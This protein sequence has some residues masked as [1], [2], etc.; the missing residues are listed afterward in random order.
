MFEIIADNYL[1]SREH[2][3]PIGIKGENHARVLVF[4]CLKELRQKYGVTGSWAIYFQ[5]PLEA[6]SYAVTESWEST[7]GY[8]CWDINSA[9]TAKWGEGRVEFRFYPN[10]SDVCKSQVWI[11]KIE[12]T[13]AEDGPV[14]PSPYDSIV[15]TVGKYA[16]EAMAA[17]ADA[18]NI[19]ETIEDETEGFQAQINAMR[20][21]IGAPKVAYLAEDM[22]DHNEIYVYVGDETGYTYGNWYYFDGS[23]FTSG[24]VYNSTAVATDKTLSVE[25]QAADGKAVGNRFK[26]VDKTIA[27][28]RNMIS[29]EIY[30]VSGIGQSASALTRI[31]DSVGMV[32]QV[33][34]ESSTGIQNDFDQALPFMD[35]KCVGFWELVDGKAYFNVKAYYGDP[36]YTEDGTM[37]DYVA[38]EHP[39][40]YYSLEGGV[41]EISSIP[42]GP[43]WHPFQ[44]FESEPGNETP[45]SLLQYYYAPAY[46]FGMVNSKALVL[47]DLDPENGSYYDL[48]TNVRTYNSDAKTKAILQPMAYSFY[49]WAKMVVEFA[50]QDIDGNVMLGVQSLQSANSTTCHFLDSTHLLVDSYNAGRV[51]GQYI[52]VTTSTDHTNGSYKATHRVTALQRCTSDGTPSSSGPCHLLTVEDLGKNY[53]VYDTTTTYYIAARPYRSGCC[54]ALTTPSGYIAANDGYHPFRYRYKENPYGNIF[55]TTCDLFNERVGTGDSDYSLDFYFLKD[56]SSYTPSSSSKPDASE[57][58]AAPFEKL[59]I[60]TPHVNYVNG[61]IKSKKYSAKYKNIWIPDVTSDGSASTYYADYAYLVFSSVVRSVRMYGSWSNGRNGGPSSFNGPYA[62]SS[63]SAHYG[64]DLFFKQG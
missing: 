27:Y 2:P 19:Q 42:H 11:T 26:D 5:R 23:E 47:P 61:Y 8:A 10:S 13:I 54:N 59:D 4:K 34:S 51:A 48:T 60:S 29:S 43:T 30:G 64:G 20:A 33:G 57:L 14:P 49:I 9:D 63:G 18:K 56:A 55:K 1:G 32:A 7:E 24:G 44:I 36:L 62:P 39:L 6:T 58:H 53:F 15:E 17:A 16:G 38:V 12:N 21:A 35:R 22:T 40:S 28:L 46:D 25:D 31:K 41:L 50:Q 52:A 37:G 3:I 45:S